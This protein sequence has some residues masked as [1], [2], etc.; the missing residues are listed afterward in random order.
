MSQQ[1]VLTGQKANCTL[2][3]IKRSV[4]SKS[5]KVIVPLYT[6]VVRPWLE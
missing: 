3:S 1:Y 4:A 6:A 5:W 2:D